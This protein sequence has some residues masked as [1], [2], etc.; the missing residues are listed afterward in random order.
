M[1]SPHK[2]TWMDETMLSAKRGLSLSPAKTVLCCEVPHPTRRDTV[3]AEQYGSRPE[4]RS[5]NNLGEGHQYP[6]VTS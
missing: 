1:C 6:P 2:F 3:D 4:G 5:I